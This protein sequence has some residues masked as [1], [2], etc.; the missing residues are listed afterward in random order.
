MIC[1][2]KDFY[3]YEYLPYLQFEK[4]FL[5]STNLL[6]YSHFYLIKL[7]KHSKSLMKQMILKYLL[8][9]NLYFSIG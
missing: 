8:I 9:L 1:S 7:F 4:S 5:V 3:C 6:P 2:Q